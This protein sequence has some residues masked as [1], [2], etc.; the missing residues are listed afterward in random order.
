M[1][2]EQKYRFL[3]KVGEV[4]TKA[5]INLMMKTKAYL[6]EEVIVKTYNHQKLYYGISIKDIELEGTLNKL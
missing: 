3:V 4:Y 1:R 5:V 2:N 6:G